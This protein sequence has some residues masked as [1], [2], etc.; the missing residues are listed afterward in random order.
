MLVS[1][2]LRIALMSCSSYCAN[3]LTLSG[4]AVFA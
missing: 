4:Y 2:Q 1:T 3:E